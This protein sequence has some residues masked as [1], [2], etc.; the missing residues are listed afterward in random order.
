M[1]GFGAVLT[2]DE[3]LVSG[4]A[5]ARQVRDDVPSRVRHNVTDAHRCLRMD[6]RVPGM[7]V[8]GFGDHDR[9]A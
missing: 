9:V 7:L 3:T 6:R 1:M 2:N 5:T 8:F 4:T